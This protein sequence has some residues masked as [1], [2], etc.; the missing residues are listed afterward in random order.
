L[1]KF[2]I[3]IVVGIVLSSVGFNGLAMMGNKAID[4]ISN[5]SQQ[6][7]SND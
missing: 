5:Y 6:T 7:L 2:S 1:I 4:S 3:G